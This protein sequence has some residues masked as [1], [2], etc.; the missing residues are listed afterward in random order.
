MIICNAKTGQ[1]SNRM[2][3]A[4]HVLALALAR[5][6][7]VTFTELDFAQ[8]LFECT[9]PKGIKVRLHSSSFWA[10]ERRTLGR[11]WDKL[12]SYLPPPRPTF[13]R[14]FRLFGLSIIS[15]WA[16][17]RD[18]E[19]ISK[20][21]DEVCAF[22]RPRFLNLLGGGGYSSMLDPAKKN[23]A[24]HMRRKDY[25]EWHGGKFFYVDDVYRRLMQQ[26]T[27]AVDAHFILF[28]DELIEMEHFNG[29]DCVCAHGSAVED[30]WLM[31]EC[32]YIMGPPSTF[33]IW[34]SYYGNVPR[35]VIESA[36]MNLTLDNFVI[37]KGL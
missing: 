33:T 7:S 1:M 20:F 35:A 9:P 24:V 34:A 19:A 8:K 2:C 29:L 32:D 3:E 25:R 12:I 18:R 14:F 22:F 17:L 15:G 26:M 16:Q 11:I 36:T 5:G 28:S 23:V 37:E 4:A 30:Q 21:H 13:H 10:F 31:S 6:E 27:S